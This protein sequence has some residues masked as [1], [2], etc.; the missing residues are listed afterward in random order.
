AD[1]W[2]Q[3]LLGNKT[4]ALLATLARE[5]GEAL[6]LAS[7]VVTPTTFGP[8]HRNDLLHIIQSRPRLM[9]EDDAFR[10]TM[11]SATL[12]P[13]L[14]DR[15]NFTRALYDEA[16]PGGKVRRAMLCQL[17][18]DDPTPT[19]VTLFYD[20]LSKDPLILDQPDRDLITAFRT[21]PELLT[22]QLNRWLA[23]LE[24]DREPV[25]F[26]ELINYYWPLYP[27]A[28]TTLREELPRLKNY[29]LSRLE[30]GPE[31]VE[32]SEVI[33]NFFRLTEVDGNELIQPLKRL[34]GQTADRELAFT[35]ARMLLDG[36]HALPR[37]SLKRWLSVDEHY[38]PTIR[39]L[40]RYDQLSLVPKR[41]YSEERIARAQLE[42][43]FAAEDVAYE[44]LTFYG[45]Q[46]IRYEGKEHRFFL[47]RYD[48]QGRVNHLAV[49]G[50]FPAEE[51]EQILLDDTPI[52]HSMMPV[53]RR[54]I[55]EE[56]ENL[57]DDLM[58][59]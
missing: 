40:Q 33:L 49:V 41:L 17:V 11:L 36:G 32:R 59:W 25:A 8:Q 3:D 15:G 51:G 9:E 23:W 21:Q 50:G 2:A 45:T 30:A 53:S 31:Q 13:E 27:G 1:H 52:N 20:L 39:L 12:S 16:E 19:D 48:S 6:Q 46:I 42:A 7:L 34:F 38:L 54:R 4:E 22:G 47:Y 44:E 57:V 24:E 55:E 5:D 18:A 29:G 26:W 58:R 14:P 10:R 37:S 28:V 56:A 35:A 43:Y